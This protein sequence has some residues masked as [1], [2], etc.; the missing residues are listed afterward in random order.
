MSQPLPTT[1][2]QPYTSPYHEF[3]RQQRPLLPPMTNSDREKAIGQMWKELSEAEKA[4]YKQ[5]L[6]QL[7]SSGRGGLRAWAPHPAL[8]EFG[9]CGVLPSADRSA[10]PIGLPAPP[11]GS[12]A[13]VIAT[14]LQPANS[15]AIPARASVSQLGGTYQTFVTQG[16]QRLPSKPMELD[17]QST[18]SKAALEAQRFDQFA[19]TLPVQERATFWAAPERAANESP[20]SPDPEDCHAMP[21]A[22]TLPTPA[23]VVEEVHFSFPWA[24][25]A[26]RTASAPKFKRA[27][28]VL[29][30]GPGERAAPKGGLARRRAAFTSS[31]SP[32]QRHRHKDRESFS[33]SF[34]AGS[35]TL[36]YHWP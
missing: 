36:A 12:S 27:G 6:T 29:M 19:A 21:A 11:S 20:P 5:G 25:A 30:R 18:S 23:H 22:P 24:E 2:A 33:R 13:A 28:A 17:A 7:A 32:E 35:R 26:G 16:G 3:C 9:A 14:F 1:N 10:L 31:G 8:L 15:V 34:W 4:A